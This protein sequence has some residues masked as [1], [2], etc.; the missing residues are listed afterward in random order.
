MALLTWSYHKCYDFLPQDGIAH[1]DHA[2][3][4]LQNFKTLHV[5]VLNSGH[6]QLAPQLQFVIAQ[7][8]Y[9]S[10]SLCRD[11][12]YFVASPALCVVLLHGMEERVHVLVSFRI[13]RSFALNHFQCWQSVFEF[14]HEVAQPLQ[15]GLKLVPSVIFASQFC[16]LVLCAGTVSDN[17]LQCFGPSWDGT[18]Q[19]T[20]ILHCTQLS[21]CFVAWFWRIPSPYCSGWT[22]KSMSQH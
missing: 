7:Y 10:I 1:C 3:G 18:I 19:V 5:I 22:I 21:V 6:Q 12:L 4:V 13:S 17:A 8:S 16:F 11:A 20:W 2:F 9:Y 15:A 14:L